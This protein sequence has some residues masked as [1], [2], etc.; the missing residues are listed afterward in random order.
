[1]SEVSL[2]PDFVTVLRASENERWALL[3]PEIFGTLTDFFASNLPV[4]TDPDSVKSSLD[5]NDDDDETLQ[6]IKQLLEE[7]IRPT[8]FED[9]GDIELVG[10]NP[11]TGELS[12]QLLGACVGCPSSEATLKD[13]IENMMKYYVPEVT[14]V[15]QVKS[16]VEEITEAEFKKFEDKL[17]KEDEKRKN[18]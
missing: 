12:L 2:G 18:K 11:V 4:L 3:K 9:G 13:G 7:R 5:I 8:I 10:W 17:R 6:F 1:M 16:Q 14:K 15:V